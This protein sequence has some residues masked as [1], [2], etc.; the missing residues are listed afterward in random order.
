MAESLEP[1][2]T[3]EAVVAAYDRLAG[4]YDRLVAPFEAGTRRTAL[5]ALALRDGDRVLEVGCGPGHALVP[6]V[7]RVGTAGQV[8]G[9]DAA[10]GMVQ[11]ARR[12]IERRRLTDRV[13]VVRG[14]AR[15]LPVRDGVVDAVFIEDTLELFAPADLQTVL[16]EFARVLADDGRLGV[17]T[18]ERSGA[19]RDAF[20]RG[21]EWVYAHLP[22]FGRVGCR[23]VY[24]ERAL[25]SAGFEVLRREHRRRG[26]VWP[27]EILVARAAQG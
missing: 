24:A 5:D 16:G 21:Y 11:R 25:E 18:M 17:V 12:R 1:T 27:V 10:A 19:E 22:G 23:P 26:A 14:D 20:I 6:L 4:P 8:V 3:N 15:S 13:A 2:V 7:E 9:L